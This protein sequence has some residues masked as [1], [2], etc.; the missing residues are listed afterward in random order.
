MKG[1]VNYLIIQPV[2]RYTFGVSLDFCSACATERARR[3]LVAFGARWPRQPRIAY[4]SRTT[5]W[6][7]ARRALRPLI[8]FGAEVHLSAHA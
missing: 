8:S 1:Y 2:K 6:G 4:R 5:E 7:L 3:T